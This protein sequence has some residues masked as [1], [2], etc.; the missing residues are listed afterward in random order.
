MHG[1]RYLDVRVTYH[2][3]LPVKFWVSHDTLIPQI[4]LAMLLEDIQRFHEETNREEI[5]FVDFHR[6]TIHSAPAGE[7]NR[8]ETEAKIHSE[9][10]QLVDKYLGPY[11]VPYNTSSIGTAASTT[12]GAPLDFITSYSATDLTP[13]M[14][15]KWSRTVIVT[16]PDLAIRKQHSFIWPPFQHV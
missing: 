8:S 13:N 6:V 3:F 10:I 4:P 1:I 15:W 16:Y 5:V 2:P 9:L 12:V 7:I 14:L 11:L